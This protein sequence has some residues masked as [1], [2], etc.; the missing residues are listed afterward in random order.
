[1]SRLTLFTSNRLDVLVDRLAADMAA[2]PLPPLAQEIVVVQSEG[3][4]RWLTLE[5]A[6]RHGVSGSLTTPF[7]RPFCR[8][9]ARRVLDAEA[10]P[11]SEPIPR[12]DDSAFG[13][14]MLSWRL[15]ARLG[16]LDADDSEV[17]ESAPAAYLADDP[18]QRKRYQLAQRLGSLYDDYQM[19]R[20]QMLA[21]WQ[22]GEPAGEVERA[23]ETEGWQAELWRHLVAPTEGGSE[24]P[25]S[26]RMR[27]L[28]LRLGRTRK[29][30]AG[31]PR[32]VSVLGVSTLPPAFVELLTA[33]AR[34][35]QVGVY[36]VS[37]TYHYWGDLRSEREQARIVR[38]ERAQKLLAGRDAPSVA[39]HLERGNALLAALGRQ[40]REFFDILQD[41][42]PSGGAWHD[43][44]FV[45]PL[46]SS[47]S[48]LAR[49][50]SD[51]LHLADRGA[52]QH[53]PPV[54][55]PEGDRSLS[56]HACHSPMREMEVLRDQLLRAFAELDGL[57]PSDVLVLVPDI[58]LY[59]PLIQA[60]FGKSMGDAPAIPFSVADRRTGKE[61]PPSETLLDVLGLAGAR[62]T[63]R[64]VF[65]LLDTPAVRRRFGLEASD[66]PEL[67]ALAE[68]TR[69]RWG[70]DGRH[71][72]RVFDV[73]V[74]EQNTWRAGLD[75]LVMGYA[76]GSS[77]APL[78][79]LVETG[80]GA[81]LPFAGDTPGAVEALGRFARFVDTLSSVLDDLRRRRSFGGWAEALRTVIDRL[82]AAES[83]D[84]ERGLQAIRDAADEL[85]RLAQGAGG[86]EDD[87]VHL[88]VVREHLGTV[89]SAEGFA[90]GFLA[91]RVTFCA[92]RPMRTIPFRVI[93]IAGL[94]DGAFPRR[95]RRPGFDLMARSRRPG[96]RSLRDDDRYLFLETL[97]AA[98]Q[99]LVLSYVGFSQR[100]ASKREPSVVLAELLDQVDRTFVSA[101][102]ESA[103]SR[104]VV[105]HRLQPWSAAYFEPEARAS[106]DLF[107]FDDG[108][109]AA[110]RALRGPGLTV[111]PFF[112]SSSGPSP[113]PAA[114]SAAEP[115]ELSVDELVS[116]WLHPPRAY[117]RGLGIVL[118]E[119]ALSD[120]ESEPFDLGGLDGYEARQWLLE[121][122]LAL[123][124]ETGDE[125][126]AER[127][128]TA[129]R[130][131]LRARGLLPPGAL[132]DTAYSDLRRRVESFAA[133]VPEASYLDPVTV[134]VGGG[135]G[136]DGA[137]TWRLT[138]RVGGRTEDG[139]LRFRCATL[140]P[141]DLVRTWIE[142]LAAGQEARLLGEDLEVR[143]AAPASATSVLDA[144]V[145]GYEQ[146]RR[147]P[148]PVMAETSRAWA[149]QARALADP[150]SL[151]R[152]TPRDAAREVFE[153][154][155]R[156]TDGPQPESRDPYVRLCFRDADPLDHP[157]FDRWAQRL[158]RPILDHVREVS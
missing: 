95:D 106:G 137:R 123:R 25:F 2:S 76:T 8:W 144:L 45:D 142:G 88:Q 131:I 117:C 59:G 54:P 12:G 48:A 13:R 85:H 42:D 18:D 41:A 82:F 146:G 128:D 34:W 67:R 108:Q 30:P 58:E 89:L 9:L 157:E 86:E 15:F 114:D 118:D 135:S 116:F 158:W 87:E 115:T 83:D 143:I 29:D 61:Q 150:R 38:R 100:D 113:G 14:E 79:E 141:A 98:R 147:R 90:S 109:A 75:R 37:P 133:R 120:A 101:D 156:R 40:G 94:D 6:R 78:E 104:V 92:L 1:M 64:E 77:E 49:L 4:Q 121:R 21:R 127:D 107:S 19:F 96:D 151:A 134:D 154:R 55:W 22:A 145:D 33:L 43:L 152:K 124:R 155:F 65:D 153:G 138:G 52:V 66:L 111:P 27:R 44:D 126:G 84:E 80:A 20:P 39:Q 53:T 5:L 93:A 10:L 23:A 46:E 68:A 122:W 57:R 105:E 139:L 60:V 73:P 119:E 50:Q 56:V 31:L 110:A 125:A 130:A 74:S 112:A 102:G 47:S 11:D 91:G 26:N 97:L 69:V 7:P 103:R 3:M 51:V 24:E 16:R 140:R 148:L 99:R 17:A 32:R 28:T 72:H 70:F 63:V 71:R 35:T 136:G 129:E 62:V 81:I 132:G 36:F 149:E